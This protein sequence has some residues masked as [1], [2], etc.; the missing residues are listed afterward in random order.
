M[1]ILDDETKALLKT[2]FIKPIDVLCGLAL[3]LIAVVGATM[4]VTGAATLKAML[5][6]AAIAA[7]LLAYLVIV[8]L[9]RILNFVIRLTA[10]FEVYLDDADTV[11]KRIKASAPP[12][13]PGEPN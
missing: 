9:Y 6:M 11:F 13:M 5:V 3:V 7:F 4:L 10:R 2:G 8:L 12:A 1:N